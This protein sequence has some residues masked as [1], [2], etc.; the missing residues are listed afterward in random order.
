MLL[1]MASV[2]AL[3]SAFAGGMNVALDAMAGERE[4]HSLV[5]L[6]LTPAPLRAVVIGKW[7]ATVCFGLLSVLLT[8]AGCAMALVKASALTGPSASMSSV[9]LW[10]GGGLV[11]LVLLGSACH[12]V[13]ALQSAS[14]KE[15]HTW[16]SSLVFV[17]MLAGMGVV[18]A[19]GA[20]EG[21]W[22]F[23]PLVGHQM[24]IDR[25]LSGQGVAAVE[26]G[27]LTAITVAASLAAMEL[28]R[29]A[30]VRDDLLTS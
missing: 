20:G 19:P 11:P 9:A 3:V 2:F 23:V 22:P 5:P 14:T 16:M 25:T 8:V 15:A 30:L 13:V 21:W 28:A 1:S 29:R 6:L 10:I 17:P 4:R 18:F 27:A 7:I 26:A 12:L 24:W